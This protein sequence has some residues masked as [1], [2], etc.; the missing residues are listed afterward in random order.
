[1]DE[2]K[3]PGL[4]EATATVQD[5][6]EAKVGENKVAV[7]VETKDKDV[8]NGTNNVEITVNVVK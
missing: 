1:M 8:L 7:K 2:V 4:V 6:T 5:I 3:K